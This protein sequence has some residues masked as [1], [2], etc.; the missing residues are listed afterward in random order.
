M[1]AWYRRNPTALKKNW[2]ERRAKIRGMIKAAKS[3]PCDD[4]GNKFPWYVMDLDHV[5]GVK[6]FNLSVAAQKLYSFAT[7]QAE[8]RKC[9]PV[10][11]NCHRERTFRRSGVV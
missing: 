8:L 1:K 2:S 10:C 6:K 5:R 3:K 9:D 7:I 11:A 4:C